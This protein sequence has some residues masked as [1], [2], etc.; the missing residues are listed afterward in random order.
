MHPMKTR[1][2]RFQ[3]F[4]ALISLGTLTGCAEE[5]QLEDTVDSR[6]GVSQPSELGGALFDEG[7]AC[8]RME[9]ALQ[10]KK[11]SLN[12]ESVAVSACPGLIRPA[13]SL[14]CVRYT[15]ASVN[16]CVERIG[17]YSACGDFRLKACLVSAVADQTSPGCVPPSGVG[18][19]DAGAPDAP[20][21]SSSAGMGGEAPEGGAG[22]AS[23]GGGSAGGASAGG[24]SAGGSSAGGA[25]DGGQAGAAP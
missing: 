23:A 5:H 13:G 15:Q 2:F 12:C 18:G 10:A 16:A 8:Q 14:A 22:G 25:S 6:P 9:T 19:A 24:A 20:D 1:A 4:A 11:S 21:A 17:G 3:A 7:D